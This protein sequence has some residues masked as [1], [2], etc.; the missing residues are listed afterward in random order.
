[1]RK[2]QDNIPPTKQE[3]DV[4]RAGYPAIYVAEVRPVPPMPMDQ[5]KVHAA[6]LIVQI[7][8]DTKYRDYIAV[9]LSNES[10]RDHSRLFPT[11]GDCCSCPS[12]CAWR[13]NVRL[14][15]TS[16][17]YCAKSA[18][19]ARSRICKTKPSDWDYAVVVRR[20]L[21]DRDGDHPDGKDRRRSS[22]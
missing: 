12:A 14:R 11:T 4:I 17:A 2:P 1:M 20:G 18:G 5:L 6:A 22:R 7:G 3:R 19:S 10:W 21:G 8:C 15:L 9:T 16:S 13:T